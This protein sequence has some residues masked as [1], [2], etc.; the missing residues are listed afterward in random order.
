MNY[1]TRLQI[2]LV[3]RAGQ[4]MGEYALIVGLVAAVTVAA[5]TVLGNNISTGISSFAGQI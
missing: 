2:R 1:L 5:W 4:A 3:E